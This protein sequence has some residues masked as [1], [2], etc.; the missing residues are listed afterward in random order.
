MT[1]RRAD[2]AARRRG[3]TAF[4]VPPVAWMAQLLVMYLLVPMACDWGTRAPLLVVSVAA[5]VAALAAIAVARRPR[6]SAA[7]HDR[8]IAGVGRIHGSL[9]LFAILVTGAVGIWID[10]CA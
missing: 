1:A 10:P 8:S 3:W 9:F 7:Q 4:T 6:G 2:V 5:L